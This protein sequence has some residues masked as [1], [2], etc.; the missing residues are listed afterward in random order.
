MYPMTD[1]IA[2]MA[3]HLW[4]G[5]PNAGLANALGVP[6]TTAKS[7]ITGARR[8]PAARMQELHDFLRHDAAII[9]SLRSDLE[10][11]IAQEVRRFK[12]RRGFFVVKDWDGAGVRTN[13]Q[14]RGGP[15]SW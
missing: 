6:V 11:Q 3:R 13:R 12:P 15:N 5:R 7:W 2:L 1:T 9:L 10:F 8:M 4:P 14:W